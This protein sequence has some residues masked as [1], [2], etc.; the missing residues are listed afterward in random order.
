MKKILILL[1]AGMMLFAF[2][3]CNNEPDK[4]EAAISAKDLDVAVDA[5][6][7]VIDDI[8]SKTAENGTDNPE[9]AAGGEQTLATFTS[10]DKSYSVKYNLSWTSKDNWSVTITVSDDNYSMEFTVTNSSTEVTVTV[11]GKNYTVSASSITKGNTI[12]GTVTADDDEE[13][14]T[15]PD[16]GEE[17][18]TQPGG[19]VGG[20]DNMD[21]VDP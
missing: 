15:S 17:E 1:L 2:T 10:G 8:N 16:D 3:A 6:K 19:D 4:E 9:S 13:E 21:P 20:T 5:Y 11:N 18:S 7:A 12:T 14:Q